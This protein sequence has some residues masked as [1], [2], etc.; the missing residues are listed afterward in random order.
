MST[1]IQLQHGRRYTADIELGYF[2]AIA[3]NAMIKDKLEDAGFINVIITGDGRRRT[4]RGQ[5]GGETR[6]VDL[7]SQVKNVRMVP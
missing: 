7:P 5:W 3:G 2:E 6:S 4:A 1:P